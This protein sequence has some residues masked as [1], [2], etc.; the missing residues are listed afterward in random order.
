MGGS[1]IPFSAS[2]LRSSVVSVLISLISDTGDIVPHDIN[3]IF[4]G[5]RSIRQLAARSCERRL[6]LALPSWPAQPSP[7]PLP[8]G[9]K[10]KPKQDSLV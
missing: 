5:C 4:L 8:V 2:W 6:G 10:S 3:L 9:S 1:G 7:S